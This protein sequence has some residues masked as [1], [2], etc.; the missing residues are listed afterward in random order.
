MDKTSENRNCAYLLT[1]GTVAKIGKLV[2]TKILGVARFINAS[3]YHDTYRDIIFDNSNFF[4]FFFFF[5]VL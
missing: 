5:C 2:H 3:I 1:Y 4:F